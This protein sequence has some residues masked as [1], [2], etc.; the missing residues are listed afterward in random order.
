MGVV[1]HSNHVKIFEEARVDFL[2]KHK[3]M[4]WHHPVGP[5]VFAVVE[6]NCRYLKPARFNDELHVVLQTKLKGLRIDFQYALY[7]KDFKEV[8]ALG[9]TRLVAVDRELKP[10]KLP[11][12]FVDAYS[13]FSWSDEWPVHMDF[14]KINN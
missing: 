6:Q 10:Q 3:L 7:S 11:K 5:F 13:K 1:H 9:S 4:H 2:L 8:L 14:K 12:E